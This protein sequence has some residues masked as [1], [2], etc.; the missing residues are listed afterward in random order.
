MFFYFI[1]PGQTSKTNRQN[2]KKISE[3]F[4]V[5]HVFSFEVDILSVL[6][7]HMPRKTIAVKLLDLCLFLRINV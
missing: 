4:K 1:G 5:R 2:D 7:K 6:M 3:Y